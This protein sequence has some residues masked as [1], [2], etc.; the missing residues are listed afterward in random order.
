MLSSSIITSAFSEFPAFSASDAGV[1]T[2]F[3]HVTLQPEKT[4]VVNNLGFQN[5]SQVKR[6]HF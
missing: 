6:T 3:G 2:F 4:Q 5:T 1:I